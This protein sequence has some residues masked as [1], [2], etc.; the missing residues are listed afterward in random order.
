MEIGR[1][2]IISQ[3]LER[4]IYDDN[5]EISAVSTENSIFLT[6]KFKPARTLYLP[7]QRPNI[8]AFVQRLQTAEIC[9]YLFHTPLCVPLHV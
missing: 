6:Y 5:L 8:T 2:R 9:H 4:K 7:F 3:L 1:R